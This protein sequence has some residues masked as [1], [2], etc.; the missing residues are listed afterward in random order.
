[1]AL[2]KPEVARETILVRRLRRFKKSGVKVDLRQVVEALAQSKVIQI[3]TST[4]VLDL[5]SLTSF[6]SKKVHHPLLFQ[7]DRQIEKRRQKRCRKKK[8]FRL[9]EGKQKWL[10]RFR[11]SSHYTLNYLGSMCLLKLRF[12]MTLISS[13][14]CKKRNK[15]V[16]RSLNNHNRSLATSQRT[17]TLAQKATNLLWKNYHK[18]FVHLLSKLPSKKNRKS[19]KRHY[20]RPWKLSQKRHQLRKNSQRHSTWATISPS[21]QIRPTTAQYHRLKVSF[22]QLPKNNRQKHRSRICKIW[23][24]K[25]SM[26]R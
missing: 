4:L 19:I 5:R 3:S 15:V 7:N 13:L 9:N 1:M 2:Q 18:N 24:M 25:R 26:Q 14:E 12:R 21:C 6:S 20:N 10:K 8:K 23:V 22:Q 16:T 11:W 17:I